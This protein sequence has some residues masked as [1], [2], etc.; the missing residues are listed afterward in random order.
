MATSNLTQAF[1]ELRQRGYFAR[2]NF[3][4]CQSCGWAAVPEDKAE[5]AV[6]YH[7]QDAD[8]LRESGE[9]Y[10]A[11]SGDPK[12]ICEVLNAHGIE[13]EHDGDKDT[14]ILIRTAA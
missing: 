5:Q 14:R 13:T 7:R 12:L 4:C 11:W 10:L 2:Q 9:T 3:T 1:K 8:D 6:F